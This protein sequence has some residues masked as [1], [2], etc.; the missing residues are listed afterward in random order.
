MGRI[1]RPG[2]PALPYPFVAGFIG[3]MCFVKVIAFLGDR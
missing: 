2:S 3:G 1:C